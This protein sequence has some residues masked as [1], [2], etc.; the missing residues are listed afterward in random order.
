MN[1]KSSNSFSDSLK[2]KIWLSTVTLAFF[3][4]VFGSISY[5]VVSFLVNDPFYAIFIPF[6][7]LAMLIA[8]FGLWLANEVVGPVEKISLLAKSLE[9]GISTSLPKTSGATETDELLETIH[10]ISG[11]VQRLVAS[12]DGVA[13][14]NLDAV[15]IQ[16]S[17]SDRISQS[18][19]K[20]LAKVSESIHA[21]QD[22]EKLEFAVRNLSEESNPL[23]NNN[24]N[25]TVNCDAISTQEIAAT[26]NY[27]TDQLGDLAALVKNSA[28]KS[29]I[30]TVEV[31]KILQ[32]VMEQDESRVYEINQATVTLK[33][34]PQLVDKIS[35]EI[36]QSAASTR[37]SIEKARRG[38]EN[39]QINFNAVSR[40]RKQIQESVKLIQK[41]G[42]SSQEIENAAKTIGDMAQR[43]NLVALNA[44]I[45][46][47]EL[48]EE[49]R[50]FVTVA[51]EVERL[52]GRAD[53]SHKHLSALNK[54]IQSEIEKVET[55]LESIVGEAAN[56]SKFTI[57]TGNLS[58]DMERYL[59]RYLQLQ[60]KIGTYTGAQ[61][62]E[63]EQAFQTLNFSVAQT[64]NF[65]GDL[66][67]SVQAISRVTHSM[68]N[69]QTAVAHFNLTPAA[70]P[71]TKK[72]ENIETPQA[73]TKEIEGETF[74]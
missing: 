61:T 5:I 29:Q 19:Q 34:V 69:L 49:G 45:Q 37:Q 22:L 55:A 7:L 26:I 46:A 72:T 38:T 50:G 52:A 40:L 13:Q 66:K 73:V 8:A 71:E 42:E 32:T 67:N 64:H 59:N 51:A 3:I 20:L 39:A 18:F 35:D 33:K 24:L 14:G 36:S 62:A 44:S 10:R 11:Q 30:S 4:C 58:G 23:K 16:N 9:R 60:E 53:K 70:P 2:G 57:E 12:M 31:Q 48:G 28:S 15:Y 43:T 1:R 68:D 63:I 56:F 65:A 21:K 17:G 27:L 47:A 25:T 74:L 6:L 41:L 54:A